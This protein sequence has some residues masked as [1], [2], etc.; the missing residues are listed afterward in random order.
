MKPGTIMVLATIVVA[1]SSCAASAQ[2]GN[3]TIQGPAGVSPATHCKNAQ[4]QIEVR[5]TGSGVGGRATTGSA[6]GPSGSGG[7]RGAAASSAP[8]GD[9]S[10]TPVA[11]ASLPP[12]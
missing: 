10:G 1:A 5:T 9:S 4:G 8:G 11:A 2:S 12:C 6:A 7:S 3:T